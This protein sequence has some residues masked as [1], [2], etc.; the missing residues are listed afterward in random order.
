MVSTARALEAAQLP[1]A[2][3]YGPPAALAWA[4]VQLFKAVR[5][6]L[7]TIAL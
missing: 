4:I 7:R 3:S 2:M 5:S 6:R 1:A